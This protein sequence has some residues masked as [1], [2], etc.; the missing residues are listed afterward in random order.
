[1]RED[2]TG[3]ATIDAWTVVYSRDGE[4]TR[5]IVIGSLASGERFVACPPDR[6]DFLAAFASREQV[7]SRGVVRRVGNRLCFEP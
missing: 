5:G 4:P 6:P 1:V 3:T 7:G 2:A